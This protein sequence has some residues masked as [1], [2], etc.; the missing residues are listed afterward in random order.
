M[1]MN[2]LAVDIGNSHG[3]AMLGM[4]DGHRLSLREVYSFP[5]G[6]ER[7]GGGLYWDPLRMISH[8]R[9]AIGEAA[10]LT[11]NSIASVG[12]DTWGVDYAMLDA[13][14]AVMGFPHT[15]R[16]GRTSGLY[17]EIFEIVPKSEV[18]RLTGIQFMEIN[19]L[20]Q[21]FADHLQS[22]W[23]MEN[24]RAFLMMPDLLN[25][26]LTGEMH[27]EYT[28]ASTTQMFNPATESW[29]VD[30][31][32]RLGIRSEILRD[33][34]YPGAVWGELSADMANECA[35]TRRLPVIAV[36]SHDTA[37][38]VAGAP[39]EGAGDVYISSG[40]WSLV[41][42]ELP[43][44]IINERAMNENFTNELGLDRRVR[45]LRNITGLWLI[46][47]CKRCWERSGIALS[48]DQIHR[49]AS[50]AA[51]DVFRVNPTDP[52]FTSPE[53][54]P[55]EIQEY[56]R[57]TGQ[58]IPQDPGE[59]ARGIYE[60]LA[61]AYGEVIRKL[62]AV[63]GIRAQTV[64]IVG[65]G[66]NADLLSKLTA[67]A[68][69]LTV[70]AGPAEATVIGNCLAQLLAAGEIGSLAEGRCIVR[71]SMQMKAFCP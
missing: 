33:V 50:A 32:E 66:A 15:Y 36:G 67:S 39:L 51:P 20:V 70:V 49:A 52:C 35:V 53:D 7:I 46:Q 2:L 37:S 12:I 38:A 59:M 31:L 47:E 61:A 11:G 58:R 69:G 8:V 18:Y 41:G 16:D 54:M 68:T 71:E 17:S 57:R 43:A 29:A 60:S 13:R 1:P 45:F 6:A 21:L 4:Y 62:E 3:R 65:G 9:A 24:A 10:R 22:P 28:N 26:W 64:H 55:S 44:P 40:T 30:M 56:C 48:Y 5:N 19:T 14:G 25:Y 23:V 27:S 63:S 34:I 42:M